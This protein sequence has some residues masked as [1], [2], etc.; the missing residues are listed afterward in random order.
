MTNNL[1]E[2]DKNRA[3][4]AYLKILNFTKSTKVKD[5]ET[6]EM[7]HCG[8]IPRVLEDY[9]IE[10]KERLNLTGQ[11]I[12]RQTNPKIADASNIVEEERSDETVENQALTLG[13]NEN[14]TVTETIRK[15]GSK[16]CLYSKSKTNGK[17]KKLGCYS[18][19]KGAQDREKQVNYFKHAK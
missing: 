8:Y 2:E 10:N 3:T 17:R 19:K 1:S 5:E 7:V 14:E 11:Y 13:E 12:C 15:V 6:G 16:W 18:S 4:D 9:W